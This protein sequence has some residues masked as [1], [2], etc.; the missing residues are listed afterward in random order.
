MSHVLAVHPDLASLQDK[1]QQ[2]VE[3][4]ALL[5]CCTPEDAELL[6]A[7]TGVLKDVR[8]SAKAKPGAS[9]C[10]ALRQRCACRS[11]PLEV[12]S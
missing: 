3:A 7:I 5:R 6:L 1:D 10:V 2:A 12:E 4:A 9:R 11:V 8:A